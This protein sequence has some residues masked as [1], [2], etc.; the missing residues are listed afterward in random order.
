VLVDGHNYYKLY[1][2]NRV[3]RIYRITENEWKNLDFDRL[4]NLRE[5]DEEI[6][7]LITLP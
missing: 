7:Q 1:E 6:M 4:R 3:D 2:A 5:T